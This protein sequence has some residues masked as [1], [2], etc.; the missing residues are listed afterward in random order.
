M[1]VAKP[2]MEGARPL[3]TPS[4]QPP[5]PVQDPHEAL[6]ERCV[7]EHKDAAGIATMVDILLSASSSGASP[8]I[9]LGPPSSSH[10]AP[11]T[12]TDKLKKYLLQRT[13]RLQQSRPET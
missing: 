1:H 13:R 8:R 2:D 11:C 7:Q 12:D 6:V 10:L 3:Q 9:P 5:L 4:P